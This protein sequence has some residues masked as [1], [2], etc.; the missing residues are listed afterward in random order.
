[1]PW[2]VVGKCVHKLNPDGSVGAKVPGGCHDTEEEAQ[3]H[4]RALYANIKE[5][6]SLEQIEELVE[7]AVTKSESW[8][9]EP[10]SSYLVVEDSQKTTTWHLAYKKHGKIDRG[11]C[12]AAYAAL[13]SNHRG[14]GYQGP[15]KAAA[16]SKLR[17]IYKSQGWPLP[18][19]KNMTFY[20]E[21]T[22]S[23]IA[24]PFDGMSVGNFKT[25]EG[26]VSIEGDELDDYLKNTKEV[27]ESTRTEG[28]EI[29]GLPID[30]DGHDHK[31]GAGWIVD[32][33]REG[34][35]LRFIPKW[36]E[37]GQQLI[38]EGVRRFFSPSFD[39]EQKV[40]IGGSM[41]N[42]PASRDERRRIKLRPV[43]LSET[44]FVPEYEADDSFFTKL[45]DTFDGFFTKWSSFSKARPTDDKNTT[46]GGSTMP[47]E[48]ELAELA[49][50]AD[51]PEGLAE[52]NDYINKQR[53][54]RV[55]E[56]LDAQT[57]SQHIAELA[58]TL[59]GGSKE[60]PKGLPV[61]KKALVA[62]LSELTPEQQKQAETILSAIVEKGFIDFEEKGH[63]AE[64]DGEAT[65]PDWAAPL[66]QD[67]LD[68]GGTMEDFFKANAD[69]LGEQK[70]YDL[71]MF[72]VKEAA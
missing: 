72:K 62:F 40:I 6:M 60:N 65:L 59:V 1:M 53:D 45:S 11:L 10:A 36:T 4:K 18:G 70:S 43:E 42:Y 34:D 55:A 28:G 63:S 50:K 24:R 3:A 8:G 2:K 31:G 29:V 71:S 56:L 26:A 27:L 58:D 19:E 38:R 32:V 33:V 9:S 66:L 37:A 25:A 23:A 54:A 12:G 22:L 7:L 68:N 64:I 20:T 16:L 30:M 13:T 52:L 67:V 44:L 46:E 41:T 17:G 57:R 49:A 69:E 15:N 5:G 14:Q 48:K 35:L 39:P 61:E 21:L 47:T 51:T